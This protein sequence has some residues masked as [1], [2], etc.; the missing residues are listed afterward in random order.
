MEPEPAVLEVIQ[1]EGEVEMDSARDFEMEEPL[2]DSSREK[3]VAQVEGLDDQTAAE[4]EV[5]STLVADKSYPHPDPQLWL[6]QRL[7][8]LHL[9][10]K[11]GQAAPCA[12]KWPLQIRPSQCLIRFH[13]AF[14]VLN[15]G[16]IVQPVV[17][18]AENVDK[19]RHTKY[20]V[21]RCP[22]LRSSLHIQRRFYLVLS[23]AYFQ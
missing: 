12:N 20:T 15:A 23:F 13:L 6:A 19:S 8:W 14:V 22:A 7:A 21:G 4:E 2:S 9:L 11:P 1:A 3:Q 10:K 17:L 18:A 5:G 16:V